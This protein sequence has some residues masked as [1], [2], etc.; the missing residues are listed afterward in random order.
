M[1]SVEILFEDTK[2]TI[3]TASG[4]KFTDICDDFDTPIF[5]GC[6]AGSCATC[7][8]EVTQGIENLSPHTNEEEVLLSILADGNPKARL[9]CQCKVLGPIVVKVL[10]PT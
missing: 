6:R 8:I 5:F 2:L 7:L 9:A 3:T 1:A 4:R 10:E